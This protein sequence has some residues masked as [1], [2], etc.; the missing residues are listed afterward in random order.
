M[1]ALRREMLFCRRPALT[2]LASL[3]QNAHVLNSLVLI[4]VLHAAG[5]GKI[6]ESKSSKSSG[7]S[8]ESRDSSASLY[9]VRLRSAPPVLAYRGGI[10]GYAATAPGFYG[11]EYNMLSTTLSAPSS[12]M[13]ETAEAAAL[14]SASVTG[15]R[16]SGRGSAEAEAE[17]EAAQVRMQRP[18]KVNMA[19]AHVRQFS[20][21]LQW[22]QGQIAT[23]V[24]VDP[25]NIVYK[26]TFASNGF[27]AMLTPAEAEQLRKH[28]AVE[29]VT[30]A[31]EVTPLT[32]HSPSFLKLPT[33]LWR[34]NGGEKSAG[35]GVVIGVIDSG[36][37]IEHPSFADGAS[38]NGSA[39]YSAP[40]KWVGKC[41][42][43]PDFPRC[44]NK[45]I[46]ARAFNGGFVR[47]RGAIDGTLDY[48]S[49][50][51]S[52]GHG[53]WCASAAAGNSGVKAVNNRRQAI[54]ATSGMAP[55]AR[56]SVYK[57]FWK[58]KG[59]MSGSAS[60]VDIDA[61]IDAA[62]ADGVDVI[63]MSLGGV[64]PYAGYFDDTNFL[65]ANQ[66]G[67]VVVCAGGNNGP[68]PLT[69]S[70]YRTIMHFSPFYLTVGAS[71]TD[72]HYTSKLR[73]G[74]G[75]NLW[76][77]GFG[78]GTR[79]VRGL[80]LLFAQ[81]A[82]AY[83]NTATD[84]SVLGG[85]RMCGCVR[86]PPLVP[87]LL[88]QDAV[89]YGSTATDV[90]VWSGVGWGGVG[91]GGRGMGGTRMCVCVGGR[92]GP[93]LLLAQVAV[94]QVAVAYG[95]TATDATLCLPGTVDSAKASGNILVCTAGGAQA[96]FV[97]NPPSP[98]PHL[99]PVTSLFPLHPQAK[100][101]IPGTVDSSKASGK[102]LVCTAGQ[103][104]F[105]TQADTAA[106][107]GARAMVLVNEAGGG[108]V[109][110]DIYDA[111]IPI[112]HLAVKEADK[113]RKYMR[114]T[115]KPV[116]SYSASFSVFFNRIAPAVAPFSAQ[117][118]VVSPS[119]DPRI[120][121]P[122]N[123]ILK[124]DILGPGLFL[125]GSSR[126]SSNKA[127]NKPGYDML[128]GT[129]MAAPHVA[130]IAALLVQKRPKWSPAQVMSAIM[131]TASNVN[132]KGGPIGR[133]VSGEKANPFEIG[134]GHVNP[135]KVSDP[136]LTY[137]LGLGDYLNFLA[138]QNLTEVQ[139]WKI[140]Q[141]KAIPAYN[142]NLPSIAVSRLRKGVVVRR[143]V[144]NVGDKAATYRAKVVAPENVRV[145]VSPSQFTVG[146]GKSVTFTVGFTVVNPTGSFSFGS[147]TWEDGAGHS[148]RSVLAVQPIAK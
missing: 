74:T 25:K 140:K 107:A 2:R 97:T 30:P 19:S 39:A 82:V 103:A 129:S 12:A 8:S 24:G 23:D 28:P 51:D 116:A 123:D 32:T 66:A 127:G 86:G 117:G 56:L 106:G 138:G 147:L 112:L 34:A 125:W 26:F 108:D 45:V 145:V 128:M 54:G 76:G 13:A 52:V 148:V 89:A 64:N 126:S 91:W 72:R 119:S 68:P 142:L 48:L 1:A 73:L 31:F 96:S 137:N 71:S 50:R 80:P 83:G 55:R 111:R 63:S 143:T 79:K 122:T 133:F 94:A 132:N 61:A 134:S 37:W 17:A 105:G 60:S 136:G 18:P 100:L 65:Y 21:Y 92:V 98:H 139:G 144:T 42:T 43:A 67:I 58:A 124:P 11:N 75:V 49:P 22:Q 141:V 33:S 6:A 46:G 29:R 70:I 95:S 4:A 9:N 87:L 113:L 38:G 78:T 131:T 20:S 109:T 59:D 121:G 27:A 57:V 7:S 120:P 15:E 101:C 99:F 40:T 41:Q 90:I 10:S 62:V 81:D 146:V 36:I 3:R 110:L 5:A 130:G 44:N 135:P 77:A 47:Y 93:P 14:S 118:P 88:A 115:P 102:I 16:A 85:M 53:S 104:S 69:Q 114:A 35:R 84:V